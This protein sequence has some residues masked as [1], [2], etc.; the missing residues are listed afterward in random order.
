M[1]RL[2]KWTIICVS[3]MVLYGAVLLF[4]ANDQPYVEN[5]ERRLSPVRQYVAN[6]ELDNKILMAKNLLA[7]NNLEKTE[8]LVNSLL[9]ENPYEGNLYMLKGDIMMRRQ[10]PIAAMYEYKEAV[11]L[12]PDFIDKK[13]KLFQGKK[14]KVTVEEAMT[15][16]ES[17]LQQN[18]NDTELKNIR[19]TVYF[20]QR[21]LAGSCG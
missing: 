21:K 18:P 12:N 8:L 11:G 5:L 1:D 10:Q 14:I 13:T 3:V 2:D 16:V 20:M 6:P 19:K 4:M 9:A 15:E 17:S 7:Q